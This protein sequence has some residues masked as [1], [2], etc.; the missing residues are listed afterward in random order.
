MAERPRKMYIPTQDVF[1]T[2]RQGNK[3]LV[4]KAGERIPWDQAVRLGLVKEAVP[5][6]PSEHK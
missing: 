5:V 6:G 2:D 1:H 4:A 3:H